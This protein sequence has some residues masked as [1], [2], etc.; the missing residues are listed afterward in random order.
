MHFICE[1]HHPFVPGKENIYAIKFSFTFLG[2]GYLHQVN[3]VY[4][5]EECPG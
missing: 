5:S 1:D 2:N 3:F 4:S